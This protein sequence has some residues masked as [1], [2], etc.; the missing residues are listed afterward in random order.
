MKLRGV[1]HHGCS[2]TP[3]CSQSPWSSP[4]HTGQRGSSSCH[5]PTIRKGADPATKQHIAIHSGKHEEHADKACRHAHG[6]AQHH[7]SG[8]APGWDGRKQTGEYGGEQHGARAQ[9][10]CRAIQKAPRASMVSVA[11]TVA[12]PAPSK[13]VAAIET[14]PLARRSDDA[15]CLQRCR[16][17][18]V[19]M[20][21]IAKRANKVAPVSKSRNP[22]RRSASLAQRRR[23]R[24]H[25]L[26]CRDQ[27]RQQSR[28]AAPA[29]IGAS[30][31]VPIG[32]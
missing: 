2:S 12:S 22:A 21:F 4:A 3:G 20:Q 9:R 6:I 13:I 32:A 19:G 17:I 14:H 31:A 30:S 26:P 27:S 29:S 10:P 8:D 15:R 1:E 23:L 24:A 25:G 28:A 7:R 11:R 16:G 18:H 5:Q